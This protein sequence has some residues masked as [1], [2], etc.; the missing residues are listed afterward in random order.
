MMRCALLLLLVACHADPAPARLPTCA[1]VAAEM[2]RRAALRKAD[3][4]VLT[5]T[6]DV[7]EERCTGDAWHPDVITCILNE[8]GGQN[9]HCKDKLT[10]LQ[11]HA[12]DDELASIF[13]PVQ[14]AEQYKAAMTR[15]VDA[16]VAIMAS[17]DCGKV[18]ADITAY[19]AR[20]K[21]ELASAKAWEKAHPEEAKQIASDAMPDMVQRM[22]PMIQKARKCE[23]GPACKTA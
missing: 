9:L 23:K 15:A 3:D 14:T 1:Q 11:L 13:A 7:F 12:L 18:A 16:I 21:R 10:P 20:S 8:H 2:Q 22:R 5:Q 17:G 19:T 4:V 6:H